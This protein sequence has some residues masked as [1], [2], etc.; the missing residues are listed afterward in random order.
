MRRRSTLRTRRVGL[1]IALS[2]C[3]MLAGAIPISAAERR[4]GD[5]ITI[6]SE[7]II[8]DDL[9]V[10]GNTIT[11][12]G[13]IKGDVLALGNT[14]T[15]NGVVEGDVWRLVKRFRSTELCAMMRAFWRQQS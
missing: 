1:M 7:E 8:N 3:I 2:L 14:I 10:S 4:S 6:N 12:N 13:T 5:G 15:I 9:Y 11:I